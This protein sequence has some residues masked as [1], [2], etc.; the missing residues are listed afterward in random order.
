MQ[1]QLDETQYG[2]LYFGSPQAGFRERIKREIRFRSEATEFILGDKQAPCLD[3]VIGNHSSLKVGKKVHQLLVLLTRDFYRPTSLGNLFSHLYPGEVFSLSTSPTRVHQVVNRS[4]RWLMENDIPIQ[5][6]FEDGGL[7]AT[8]AGPI[9]LRVPLH[10]RIPD[11]NSANIERIQRIFPKGSEVSA[12]E[13]RLLLGLKTSSTKNFLS[14]AVEQGHFERIGES[15]RTTY[16]V[17]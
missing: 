15:V 8:L 16:R 10:H 11:T 13:V 14:W 2:F 1:N 3:V 12:K 5:L 9:S 17:R 6:T 7:R 4:R